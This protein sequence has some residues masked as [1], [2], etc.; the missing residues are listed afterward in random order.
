MDFKKEIKL[1]DL[2]PKRQKGSGKSAPKVAS[3]NKKKKA[4]Q[5]Y[6]GVK[7]GAS[8]IA[9]AEVHNNGGS[10]LV[11]LAREPLE[12]GI[13]VGGEVR[14]IAALGRALDDFFKK[15]D[16]PRKGVRLGI[17]TNRVGVRVLDVEGIDD[18]KQL[19][20]AVT[21]RA[22]EALS[23]PMDQAV[24]DYHVVGTQ[25]LDG[26]GVSHRVILAA[27]YREPIDHFAAA[28]DAA[29]IQLE[30]IDVEAFA[31][32][33]AV[34]PSVT[35]TDDER[36]AVVAL[37]L[38]HDRTTLAIS[39]GRVCD[40]TRVLEWGGGRLD[41]AIAR[42]LG[43]TTEEADEVK[44]GLSLTDDDPA[45]ARASKR[46]QARAD[47]ARTRA[48]RLAAV[49][50]GTAR[51]ARARGDPRH[52]RHHAHARVRRRARAA[53]ARTRPVGRS[54]E[55]GP[56]RRQRH[57]AERSCL[58]GNRDR[59]GGG[60]VMDAVN[61]LPPEYRERKRRR[62]A[63]AANL[64]GRKTLRLGGGVALLFAVLLGG[65]FFHEHQLVT[66]KKKELAN[67]Q[68]QIAAVQP[69]VDTI[70]TAQAAV[71][72]RLSLASSITSTRMNWDKALNDFGKII[73]TSSYLSASQSR[74]LLPRRLRQRPRP[75]P[76]PCRRRTRP[77]PPR[78]RH[79]PASRR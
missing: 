76:R 14:D 63:P 39:D 15:H 54:A 19:A 61:L 35:Q 25:N 17:G 2:I 22:H 38:G 71:S 16:L 24:M 23:I 62:S 70:K 6:V 73:P 46:R 77:H 10:K 40:F 58:S 9:A 4:K 21:F 69:Q 3:K 36:T 56:G 37:A 48:R 55:C 65:L 64:D 49:L 27:A 41:A 50:P 79:L 18:D 7:V 8:Q 11:K 47:D 33:R 13:V 66:S 74:L 34:A 72:G 1:S 57:G 12:A 28:F 32:L 43:V 30:A 29:D 5:D 42:E 60:S 75:L 44:L 52:R 78:R 51:L 53:R 26:G 45:N 67:N 20:N 68:A 59:T 31:L